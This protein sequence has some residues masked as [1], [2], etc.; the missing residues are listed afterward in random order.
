MDKILFSLAINSWKG[1][2][3]SSQGTNET[4]GVLSHRLEA[5]SGICRLMWGT[6]NFNE[7]VM[8]T[9]SL[10]CCRKY[11][12]PGPI[13][14]IASDQPAAFW[15]RE[16]AARRREDV[17]IH[18]VEED[19]NDKEDPLTFSWEVNKVVY[20]TDDYMLASAQDY[21]PGKPGN[22][23]HVWQATMGPDCV[24]FV[25]HPGNLSE[26]DANVPNLW[27]GNKT[28]PQVA[29]WGDLLIC[30]YLLPEDDWTGFTHAYF[31]AS[32]FDEYELAGNW[33]FARKEKAY[34]ALYAARGFEW[35]TSGKTALRELRS[36]GHD[37]LWICQMGQE[38]LDGSFHQF[39]EK[40]LAINLQISQLSV[41]FTSL[42]GDMVSF[43]WQKPM[44]INGQI[45]ALSKL[46]H[47]E[48]SYCI[49]DIPA[50]QIEIFY[51]EEGIRLSF[52]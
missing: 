22:R 47:Y 10:A 39:K 13:L 25:N 17:E 24:V 49:A 14:Q 42:R 15:S 45:Q 9:V 20:K 36:H 18:N 27:L 23:E 2:L 34:L 5:T 12:L 43:T 50:R 44:T 30:L 1:M 33:A 3:G 46:R 7:N 37:N 6:G 19:Q 41:E 28:L 4:A 35:V 16:R 48:N 31:P 8:G 32:T 21:Y 51:G 26:N 40:I 52:Q 29:Q 38:L 11:A